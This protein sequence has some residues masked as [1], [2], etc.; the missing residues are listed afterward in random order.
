MAIY[1]R[2]GSLGG[3]G[4]SSTL[5]DGENGRYIMSMKRIAAILRGTSHKHFSFGWGKMK[6]MEIRVALSYFDV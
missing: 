3:L 5:L 6:E 2:V 4:T 1:L